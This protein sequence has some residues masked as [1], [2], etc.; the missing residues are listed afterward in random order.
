MIGGALGGAF[1]GKKSRKNSMFRTGSMA[2][3][4]TVGL[5]LLG[6]AM[7]AF[8]HFS[9]SKSATAP[10]SPPPGGSPLPPPPPPTGAATMT[11]PPPPPGV[12][13]PPP[14][15]GVATQQAAPPALAALPAPRADITLLIQAMIAAAAA[16]GRIDDTERAAI[17]QRAEGNG[18]DADTR[19]F[20]ERELAAPLTQAQI[21]ARTRPAIAADVYAASLVAIT[22]DT[23]QE[24]A[25]LDQLARALSLD[26]N[27]R[28]TIHAQLAAT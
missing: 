28:Q 27:T 6:V 19:A 3:K 4:A 10:V 12:S 23:E 15:H 24:R 8:E 11:P 7:A 9:Q 22:L 17:L 26:D 13:A 5:G 16:D 21:A 2:T 1:G 20:L 18:L 25:Y 14:L